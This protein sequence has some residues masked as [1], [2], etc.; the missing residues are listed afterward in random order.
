MSAKTGEGMESVHRWL[1]EKL[2]ERSSE[3]SQ[4]TV[5]DSERR[6]LESIV[7]ALSNVDP[8]LEPPILSE[9]LRN[10]AASVGELLG[11]NISVDSLDYIFSKMCIGK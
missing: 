8:N 10:A 3:F 5:S 6:T 4:I 11:M 2:R 7:A 9:E 1:S